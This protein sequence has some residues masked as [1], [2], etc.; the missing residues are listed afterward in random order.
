[1]KRLF[2][3]RC[4][5]DMF[6]HIIEYQLD[7]IIEGKSMAKYQ[8]EPADDLAPDGEIVFASRVRSENGHDFVLIYIKR[9]N[10]LLIHGE[11]YVDRGDCIE[12]FMNECPELTPYLLKTYHVPPYPPSDSQI[13]AYVEGETW[14][15][16]RKNKKGHV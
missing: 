8:F 5:M 6:N 7:S 15:R 10:V 9:T 16:F 1:M 12:E 2:D 14:N 11:L 4:P 13:R 3:G